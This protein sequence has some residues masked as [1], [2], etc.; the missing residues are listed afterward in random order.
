MTEFTV[1]RSGT[2]HLVFQGERL[3]LA[4]GR[5]QWPQNKSHPPNR[6]HVIAIYKTDSGKYVVHISFRCNPEFDDPYDEAEVFK[7]PEDVVEYL[8]DFDPTDGIRGWPSEKHATQDARLRTALT[9][10]FE[11]LVSQVLA[12]Q[13]EFAERI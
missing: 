7:N 1:P 12:G 13:V 6:Y 9:N 11:I 3:G 10:N 4:D 2:S 8:N 5:D